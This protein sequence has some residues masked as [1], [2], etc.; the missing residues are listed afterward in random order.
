MILEGDK[1]YTSKKKAYMNLTAEEF[2]KYSLELLAEQTQNL[3]IS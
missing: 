3:E 2:E 1:L